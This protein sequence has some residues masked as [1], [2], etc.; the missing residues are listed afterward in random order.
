MLDDIVLVDRWIVWMGFMER[1]E[2]F[3]DEMQRGGKLMKGEE[4]QW[5][6]WDGY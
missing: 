3:R 5:E 2:T 1:M 4:W 6:K